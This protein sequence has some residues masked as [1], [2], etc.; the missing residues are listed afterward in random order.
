MAFW[1]CDV[2][3]LFTP[4]VFLR[5]GLC[6]TQLLTSLTDEV[7]T[8]KDF[9]NCLCS[10][11]HIVNVV[12]NRFV[13]TV[14]CLCV[15][16]WHRQKHKRKINIKKECVRHTQHNNKTDSK[17][18]TSQVAQTGKNGSRISFT[19]EV[20]SVAQLFSLI[21]N[22]FW[23]CCILT[24]VFNCSLLLTFAIASFAIHNLRD[25]V[26]RQSP[27]RNAFSLHW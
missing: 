11:Y 26:T 8:H 2:P 1:K 5:F 10:V 3:T 20:S 9:A 22:I 13:K 7:L 27:R 23:S 24:R 21:F 15:I 19:W 16:Y 4:H 18:P 25:F 12:F 6:G 14:V 17:S